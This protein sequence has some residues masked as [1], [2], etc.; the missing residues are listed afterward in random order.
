MV[1]MPTDDPNVLHNIAVVGYHPDGSLII[2]DPRE[3]YLQE[4]SPYN[5]FGS[6]YKISITGCN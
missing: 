6:Y 1:D 5:N 3:G 4:V 2:M